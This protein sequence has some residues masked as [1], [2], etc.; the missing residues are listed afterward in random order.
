MRFAA[1]LLLA[2]LYPLKPER[3]VDGD[4]L[5]GMVEL[6]PGLYEHVT[7][8]LDCY[9]APERNQ[10]GGAEATARLAA[11][12]DGG[13][14]QLRTTWKRDKYGRTLGEPVRGDAGFCGK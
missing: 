10:D 11:F 13:T 7:V 2:A 1:V 8:R 5:A 6:R 4:T 12:L 3:A 9:N 14:Y